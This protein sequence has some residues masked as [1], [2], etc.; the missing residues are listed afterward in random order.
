M[1]Y[2]VEIINET[3]NLDNFDCG[4]AS[5][6]DY[7]KKE[8]VEANRNLTA[9]TYVVTE[10]HQ[11]NVIA[12]IR[13]VAHVLSSEETNFL[14]KPD[15][16]RAPA[17]LIAQLGVDNNHKG[18]NIGKSLIQRCF[19]DTIK[20]LQYMNFFAI[21]VDAANN[22]LIKYYEKQGFKLIKENRKRLYIPI[23]SILQSYKTYHAQNRFLLFIKKIFGLK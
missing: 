6:N 8:A 20:I 4:L 5:V 3:H 16:R 22:K 17:I 12:F 19:L 10:K 11:N 13:V 9:K 2:K 21:L 1:K 15:S 14:I 23:S 18:L 7:L